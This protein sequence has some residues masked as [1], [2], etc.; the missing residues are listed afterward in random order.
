MLRV[1]NHRFR[2][3]DV[4]IYRMN[5]LSGFANPPAPQAASPLEVTVVAVKMHGYEVRARSP[6]LLVRGDVFHA[7]HDELRAS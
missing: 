5:P 6:S 7:D 4:A 2:V 3:L 1:E